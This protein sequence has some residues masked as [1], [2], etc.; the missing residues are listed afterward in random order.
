M[1]KKLF[2]IVMYNYFTYILFSVVVCIPILVYAISKEAVKTVVGVWQANAWGVKDFNIEKQHL[3]TQ[4][5][6]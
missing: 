6:I 4:G 3:K 5:V 1:N 2:Q